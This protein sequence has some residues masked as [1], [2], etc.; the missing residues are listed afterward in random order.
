MTNPVV[1]MIGAHSAP[2]SGAAVVHDQIARRLEVHLPNGTSF[3]DVRLDGGIRERFVG[4][5]ESM[6]ADVAVLTS[7]PLPARA[8]GSS[9]LPVVYDVRWRWTR[10]RPSRIYRHL[11][12][13]RVS[14]RSGHLLTISHTVAEQLRA[15]RLVPDGGVTVLDLGPGQFEDIPVPAVTERDPSVLLVGAASHKRNELAATLLT[16][17]E[18]VRRE[19]RVFAISVSERTLEILR[20]SIPESRLVVAESVA[21]AELAAYFRQARSYLALGYS[22][23]FGFPYIEAAYCGCDV[24]APRQALTIELMGDSANELDRL[25]PVPADIERA[26]DAWETGRV[27]HLQRHATGRTWDRTAHQMARLIEQRLP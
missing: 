3:E 16:Q 17:I 11:D 6:R 14:R 19:Y 23:G 2:F 22:E 24:I 25:D 27:Q 12:L 13:I 1:K 7:T 20:A 18:R 5:P 4:S 15:L 9:L 21:V 10:G 26:L 8:P